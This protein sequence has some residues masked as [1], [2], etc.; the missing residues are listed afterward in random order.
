MMKK[1]TIGVLTTC[2]LSL[3]VLTSIPAFAEESP[4]AEFSYE[5]SFG[6]EAPFDMEEHYGDFKWKHIGHHHQFMHKGKNI[7]FILKGIETYEIETEGKTLKEVAN[8][9]REAH[10]FE[11]AD[12]LGIETNGKELKEIAKVVAE[13]KLL[14]EAETYGI[15]TEGKELRDIRKEVKEAKLYEKAEEF[16]ISTEGKQLRELAKEVRDAAIVAKAEELGIE[17]EGKETR[18]LHKLIHEAQLLNKAQE[19]GIETDGKELK[20]I[21]NEVFEALKAELEELGIIF[22][23]HDDITEQTKL[24]EEADEA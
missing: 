11:E 4:E 16:G 19:L 2:I 17:T 14:Q 21:K 12:K 15:E 22:P 1:K 24:E 3:G 8:E 20:E 6:S 18:E 10:L 9:V 13:A 23:D 7:N 5:D